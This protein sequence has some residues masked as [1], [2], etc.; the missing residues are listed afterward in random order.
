MPCYGKKC[1]KCSR[2]PNLAQCH[3]LLTYVL[4]SQEISLV[5]EYK[6]QRFTQLLGH[7]YRTSP[8]TAIDPFLF[9]RWYSSSSW[10]NSKSPTP[11]RKNLLSRPSPWPLSLPLTPETASSATRTRLPLNAIPVDVPAFAPTVPP[12]WLLVENARPANP[13]MEACGDFASHRKREPNAAARLVWYFEESRLVT[14][15]GKLCNVG[16]ATTA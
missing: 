6:T 13:F 14:R 8:A 5:F 11:C 2:S 3:S 7:H 16:A 15:D 12:S 4:H 10:S 1:Q 9:F